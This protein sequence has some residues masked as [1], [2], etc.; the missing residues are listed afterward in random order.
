MCDRF[1]IEE[2]DLKGC[3]ILFAAYDREYEGQALVVFRRNRKLYEVNGSH[4]SCY[5][6]EGQ[7]EPE[8]TSA[9]ALLH[10]I[11]KG[12]LGYFLDSFK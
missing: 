11:E 1:Q 6:L 10:R 9:E 4:C 3:K 8:Q 2:S 12:S 5:G 7:W